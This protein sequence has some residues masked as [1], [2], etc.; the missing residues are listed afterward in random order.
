MVPVVCQAGQGLHCVDLLKIDVERA[1]L[2]VLT[3]VAA[4][5]WC[6]F[7]WPVHAVPA[8]ADSHARVPVLCQPA[9]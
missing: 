9:C 2:D 3:G 1:E 8:G 7:I 5:D 6:A 4:A